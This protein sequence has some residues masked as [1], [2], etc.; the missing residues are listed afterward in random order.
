[1]G[2]FFT[3]LFIFTAY[4]SPQIVFGALSLYH[5]EIVI[6]VVA[7]VFS[8]FSAAGSGIFRMPQTYA[9]VGLSAAVALSIIFSGWL[10][11]APIALLEFLPNAMVFFFIVANVKKP[12]HL[13]IL[14]AVLCGVALF[15]TYNGD[16]A[17]RHLDYVSPYIMGQRTGE[18]DDRHWLIRI[19]G[20]SFLNDPNDLAQFMV[21]LIPC[22]FFLWRKRNIVFNFLV[23][24]LP[25]SGLVYGMYLSRSRGGMLAL[26]LC[27]VVAG[28]KKIGTV[29]ALV[30]A[31]ILLVGLSA[32]G[33]TGG[34]DVSVGDDRMAAWGEGLILLRQHPIFG[35][36]YGL[37]TNHYEITAHNS[38][39]VCAAEL[40]LFGLI[41]WLTLIIPTL[42]DAV[43]SSEFRR[44]PKKVKADEAGGLPG[45][46]RAGVG[47]TVEPV[48]ISAY[49]PRTYSSLAYASG[50]VATAGAEGILLREPIGRGKNR[51]DVAELP[52]VPV[53]AAGSYPLQ[54]I[55]PMAD[56][57]RPT[58]EEM[59]RLSGL[60]VLSVAAFLGAGWFLSRS[61]TM[62]LFVE[63]GIAGAVYRMARDRGT[64]PAP[65]PLRQ[66][67]KVSFLASIGL[68]VFLYIFLRMRS[69]V[70]M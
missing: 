8:I 24:I 45:R 12:V 49:S 58:E 56:K 32:A 62:T 42:R 38:V 35:V 27:A 46:R 3:T 36:G 10:G 59:R 7:L 48:T 20:Q 11:G 17:I 67:L 2:L 26:V 61:Y 70:G 31:A 21:G 66:A 54:F 63:M 65:W 14:I 68:I 44:A 6:A 52:A 9:I 19:R 15:I 18:A 1:M 29:P 16:H 28:R 60:V 57:G 55:D 4:V 64:G 39:V 22:M 23:V 25:V 34:R 33:F 37:F 53:A 5:I 13:K 41:S 40:G 50:V 69:L 30:L 43:E 47:A 51:G